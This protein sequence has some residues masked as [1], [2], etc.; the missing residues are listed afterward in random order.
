MG[1][2]QRQLRVLQQ[3]P[4]VSR[5]R[6]ELLSARLAVA[7]LSCAFSLHGPPTGP[8]RQLLL[9]PGLSCRGAGRRVLDLDFR[10]D[11]EG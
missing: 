3:N 6:D 4:V 10:G 2:W 1:L 7:Y 5:Q 11:F 9:Q 8:A